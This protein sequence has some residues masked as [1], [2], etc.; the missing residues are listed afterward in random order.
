M[1]MSPEARAR[2]LFAA[3]ILI[4]AA[5]AAGWYLVS[6][7]QHITYEIRSA[8]S[9][10]G[11]IAGAPVEF[12]GVEVGRIREVQLTGPRSVRILADIQRNAPITSATRATIT[13]RGL[14]TRGFTGYVYISLEDQGIPGT[15]LA[16]AAGEGY[17][18]IATAPGSSVSL[19]TSINQLNENMRVVTALLQSVLDPSTVQAMKQSLV[20]LDKVTGTLAANNARLEELMANAERAG[21][22]L[23]PLLQSS[24]SAVNTLQ[25]Q[26]LPQAQS[27][28][29]RFN[30]LSVSMN[31]RLAA[32]L[33]NSE[34]ASLHFVPL[35][36]SGNEAVHSL[37]NQILPEAHRTLTRLDHLSTTLDEAASRIRRNP[38]L[39]LRGSGAGVAGPGES[40]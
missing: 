1:K 7:R 34:Q 32:I 33:A 6:A 30:D 5:A 24:Q 39:L 37:Q 35:L 16:A 17:P 22:Q 13:G 3:A 25:T 11:L 29:V 8:E 28:L 21:R 20:H 14:A 31:E 9:V 38:S 10:S 23:P 27:A 36:Q 4:A 2:F 26:V 18:R 19:D 40:Q 12:H 15:G